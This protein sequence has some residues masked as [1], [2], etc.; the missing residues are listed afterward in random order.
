M[1]RFF[2]L[3]ILLVSSVWAEGEREGDVI[4]IAP[5]QVAGGYEFFIENHG[6]EAYKVAVDV[7]LTN[8]NSDIPFP[9]TEVVP[10][11][12]RKRAFKLWRADSSQAS[13]YK[14][15]YKWRHAGSESRSC[16]RDLFCIITE[17]RGDSLFFSLDNQQLLPIAVKFIPTEF[18]NLALNTPMPLVKTY[19]GHRRTEMFVA[20]LMDEWGDWKHG[21]K[22][23]W[24]YGVA[25]AQHDDSYAYALPYARGEKYIMVQGPNGEHSHQGKNAYDWEMPVG[26]RVH[27][28]REGVVLAV[29]DSFTVSGDADYMK[30]EANTIEIL[31]P[32][33]TIGRYSHLANDGALVSTGERIRRGQHLGWSGNTGYSTGPHLHFDVIR[34]TTD[35][36]FDTIPVRFQV[37][38]GRASP[39]RE[40][41]AVEAF[42][43]F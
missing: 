13:G 14:F 37:S 34:L 30:K 31:H 28:A 9:Y 2:L 35:L 36:E 27:A 18:R 29:I 15:T 33:G 10:P 19:A 12:S 1:R 24:Q 17:M 39:L 5:E 22:Y 20:W 43:K 38:C 41:D 4:V 42:E 6:A 32:D 8:M 3:A 11:Q 40:G 23:Q 26:T 7:T 21:F 16:V 25:G